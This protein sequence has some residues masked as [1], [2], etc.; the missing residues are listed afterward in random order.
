MNRKR[1]FFMGIYRFQLFHAIHSFQCVF[2]WISSIT[3]RIYR[4]FKH[5]NHIIWYDM[6]YR[7]W[8]NQN[9]MTF[10]DFLQK[11]C[12]YPK[13]TFI[14]M[15]I[16]VVNLVKCV[17]YCD[18]TESTA[19]TNLDNKMVGVIKVEIVSETFPW[20]MTKIWLDC[21]FQS[22]KWLIWS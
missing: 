20:E 18:C 14:V 21:E 7:W 15:V 4:W 11:I 8:S 6:W 17:D 1:L 16:A 2:V 12:K 9:F 5:S 13:K 22:W 10:F 19:G 3:C